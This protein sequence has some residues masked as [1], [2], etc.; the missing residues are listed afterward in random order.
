M[1]TSICYTYIYNYVY[2]YMCIYVYTYIYIYIIVCIQARAAKPVVYNDSATHNLLRMA[3][4]SPTSTVGL[5]L[6]LPA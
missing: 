1:Y 2:T 3:C 5:S 4:P 6:L